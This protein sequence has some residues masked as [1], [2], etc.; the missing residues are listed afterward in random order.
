M[1]KSIGA[2]NVIDYM[3]QDFTQNG[4]IYDVIFDT[5]NTISVTRTL[6]SLTKN[7]KMILSA[8]GMQQM[9]QGVWVS[10]TSNKK[11]MTGTISHQTAD[12]I[13]LKKLIEA[14]KLKPVI[15][16]TYPLNKIAEA[17]A[18]AE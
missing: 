1:V 9:L 4:E 5:V 2:D 17:H 6:K 13:F 15:D 3:K 7:G 8:A 10:M 11:V 16:R 14:G 18:Y 12:I